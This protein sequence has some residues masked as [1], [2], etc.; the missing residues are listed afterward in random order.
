[1]ESFFAAFTWML[2]QPT[3]LQLTFETDG[4]QR[5]LL[6][7]LAWGNL[8]NRTDRLKQR[9]LEKAGIMPLAWF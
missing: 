8:S 7:S 1:M 5:N 6:F 9:G 2:A 3:S 4:L